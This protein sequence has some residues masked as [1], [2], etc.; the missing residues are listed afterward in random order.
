MLYFSLP[1]F[2]LFT[3]CIKAVYIYTPKTNMEPKNGGL[4]DDLFFST[5][6]RS[7]QRLS[8]FQVPAVS[9]HGWC[10]A[11][12]AV[13]WFNGG[14]KALL[15]T[16]VGSWLFGSETKIG[17]LKQKLRKKCWKRLETN[18]YVYAEIYNIN[19]PCYCLIIFNFICTYIYI[20]IW[21]R[22]FGCRFLG[23]AFKHL[24]WNLQFLRRFTKWSETIGT[25]WKKHN[26]T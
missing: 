3:L 26:P 4:E 6:D 8:D 20:H 24:G 7:F 12:S 11:H 25:E 16:L 17:K 21:S 13:L 2:T 9:F 5:D 15:T 19:I 1:G 22:D 10:Q 23:G 14:W 18:V